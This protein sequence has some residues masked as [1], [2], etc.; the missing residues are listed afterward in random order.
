MKFVELQQHFKNF[1]IFSLD[2]IRKVE[3]LFDRR[4]LSEW[5]EKGYIQKIIRKYYIF[6]NNNRSDYFLYLVAN[7]L[8]Q[9]S[10]VSLEFALKFY[11]LIPEE[12]F[13]ITSVSTRKT[14][15]LKTPLSSFS[16]TKIH[17]NLFW[18]YELVRYENR[19]LKIASME[20]ALLDLLYFRSDLQ[21]D[22][23]FYEL[24]INIDMFFKQFKEAVFLKYI[25][26]FHNKSLER[27]AHNF[28]T[29]IKN[30]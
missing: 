9:P 28:L 12:V 13:L 3:P 11:N 4:R 24:R 19:F 7:T 1:D 20:K 15:I 25:E 14:Q 18:G 26:R 2:D 5:Q 6:Q 21:N 8:Y 16:Y 17:E 27:R 30:A 10:Y 23:D 29:F 22:D